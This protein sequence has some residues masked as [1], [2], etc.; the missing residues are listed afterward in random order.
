MSKKY[1]GIIS[2][3]ESRENLRRL[4]AHRS[5]A[6]IPLA[7]KYR[8]IDFALSNMVNAG[9]TSVAVL[10][11]TDS[12][13]LRDHV[14]VGRAWDLNRR[15][16]GIFVFNDTSTE[17]STYDIKMLKDNIEFLNM[18][19]EE[20]I[21]FSST[22]LISKINLRDAIKAHEESGAEVTAVYKK[23]DNADKNY[24]ECGMYN[25]EGDKISSV[26]KNDGKKEKGNVSMEIF[27]MS[28]KTL[29][30]LIEKCAYINYSRNTKS[31]IYENIEKLN[32]KG[33]EYKGYLGCIN[34]LISYF[35]TNMD[36]LSVDIT[37]ELFFDEE[38]PVY[39]KSKDSA[40]TKYFD[41][42]VVKHS[43]VANG[44]IIK[45]KVK[46]SIVSRS[47]VI[48]EGAEIENSII[49]QNCTIKSGT[50]IKNVILDKNVILEE[51]TELRGSEFYPLIIEKEMYKH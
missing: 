25:L 2:A 45:G 9:I 4:A 17:R 18:A 21:V 16:G 29:L 22:Y 1:V 3:N 47:A 14:G 48:E 23:V 24:I 41:G 38:N 46:N 27:I 40:P 42:S 8:V 49:L 6:A 13:S 32:I 15:H 35:R 10:G 37:K 34:S 33:F 26:Y 31:I 43:M 20:S 44:C 30:E 7:G 39:S 36:M 28:K 11:E 5:V 50:K 19:K 12:R 51:G